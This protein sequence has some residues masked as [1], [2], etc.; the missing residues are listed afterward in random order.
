MIAIGH[1]TGIIGNKHHFHFSTLM[2]MNSG[3]NRINFNANGTRR[4][5]R[6]VHG[7]VRS[8]GGGLIRMPVIKAAVP[9]RM[10]NRFN[11]KRVLLGPTSRNAK[12]VTKN[13]IHTILRLTNINSVLSGSLNAGAPVGV[14]HTALGNLARLGHTRSMTGLHNGSMRRLLKWKKVSGN[15]WAEDGPRSRHS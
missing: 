12:M 8:T 13:P 5:P 9:R 2:M 1:M 3:G 7:T 6:T 15:R 14:I 4:I 11:T 10:V